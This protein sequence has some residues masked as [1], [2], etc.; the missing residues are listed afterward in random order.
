MP[1]LVVGSEANLAG[2]KG[3]LFSDKV[4]SGASEKVTTAIRAANPG[5]DFDKLEPGTVLTVPDLPGVSIRGD[6]SLDD[7]IAKAADA[8]LA[9]ASEILAGLVETA[10]RQEREGEAERGELVKG[11]DDSGIREAA[12]KVPGLADDLE[13]TRRAIGEEEGAAKDRVAALQNAQET[14]TKELAELTSILR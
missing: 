4:S 8:V 7:G 14:W 5:V 1:V 10:V 2:L 11:M 12:D 9:Q 3:R 6:L 13:Q